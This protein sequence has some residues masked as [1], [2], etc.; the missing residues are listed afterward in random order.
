[1][2]GALEAV[3]DILRHVDSG[4]LA[5]VDAMTALLG[6]QAALRNRQRLQT[7]MRSAR[8]PAAK[9]LTDFIQ[10]L[11]NAQAAGQ[12]GRRLRVLG[13]PPLMI[14]DE[15]GYPPISR[16]SAMI[17]YQLM[18]RCYEHASTIL[19]S[20]KP[21]EEWGEV[22]GGDV[23]AAALIDRLLHH[24]HIVNIRGNNYRILE[25]RDLASCIQRGCAARHKASRPLARPAG[26]LSRLYRAHP[27]T[28]V[29]NSSR[30]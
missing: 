3:D 13:V 9:T 25:H 15:I 10:S 16:T 27:P 18:S 26:D 6:S 20:D 8:L 2:P 22:F 29:S 21:F 19:T 7:A 23:I 1:M 4:L 5:A 11:E 17:F 24:C 28:P 12:L 30:Y 14:I